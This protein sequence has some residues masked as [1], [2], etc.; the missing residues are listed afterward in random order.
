MDLTWNPT[1]NSKLPR[2]RS[3]PVLNIHSDSTLLF[4]AD[5][6]IIIEGGLNLMQYLKIALK[7]FWVRSRFNELLL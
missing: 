3:G 4:L 7:D 5:S 1:E 6:V 2:V